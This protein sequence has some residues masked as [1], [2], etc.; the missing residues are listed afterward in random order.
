VPETTDPTGEPTYLPP[1]RDQ[2]I[3]VLGLGETVSLPTGALFFEWA[4]VT[5]RRLLPGGDPA[6]VDIAKD[7]SLLFGPFA[8]ERVTGPAVRLRIVLHDGRPEV[9]EVAVVRRPEDPEIT[10]TLLAEIRLAEI[11]N[12]CVERLGWL[13]Y[14]PRFI[15]P[16]ATDEERSDAAQAAAGQSAIASRRRRM[17][18]DALLR[19]VALI[20]ASDATGAP[21]K[22]VSDQLFTSHRN[23]TRWVALARK[24]GFLAPF[25][26]ETK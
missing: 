26:E 3:E 8:Q 2:W 11:V 14:L 13:A 23:A 19:D 6:S 5:W 21:T 7:L 24:R 17:V 12:Y 18:T 15:H 16:S 20:Y 22:A 1:D 10:S 25:G 9:D 4:E